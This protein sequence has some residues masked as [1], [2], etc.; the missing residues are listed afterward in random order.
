MQCSVYFCTAAEPC[1]AGED[2]ALAPLIPELLAVLNTQKGLN[3]A[4]VAAVG[5]KY[6]AQ[7]QVGPFDTAAPHCTHV[8]AIS[9]EIKRLSGTPLIILELRGA[10]HQSSGKCSSA[11]LLALLAAQAAKQWP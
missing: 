11:V 5:R 10:L 6:V 9:L 1:I 8:T 7:M 3:P 2:T 4:E